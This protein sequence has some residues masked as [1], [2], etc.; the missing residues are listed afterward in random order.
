MCQIRIIIR[1]SQGDVSYDNLIELATNL[2]AV[3][4]PSYVD[5]MHKENN[6][7]TFHYSGSTETYNAINYGGVCVRYG[8]NSGRIREVATNRGALP[9][10][11]QFNFKNMVS[12]KFSKRQIEN[13]KSGMELANNILININKILLRK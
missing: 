10:T 8:I 6:V 7:L 13:F 9:E 3:E 1:T 11:D 2:Q 4:R 12:N 5:F